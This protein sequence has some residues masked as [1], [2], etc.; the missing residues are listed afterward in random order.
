MYNINKGGG[1]ILDFGSQY[2]QLIARR[3]RERNVFSDILNPTI[4]LNEILKREPL[5]IIL[6]GGPSSV[7]EINSPKLDKDIIE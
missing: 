6:S 1:I 3:I 2:T 4:S 5:G 7:N